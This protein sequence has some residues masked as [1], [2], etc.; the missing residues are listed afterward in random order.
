MTM[1]EQ[2][3]LRLLGRARHGCARRPRTSSADI[4]PW[5]REQRMTQHGHASCTITSVRVLPEGSLIAPPP[6]SVFGRDHADAGDPIAGTPA[7]AHDLVAGGDA[8][9]V[10]AAGAGLLAGAI[11]TEHR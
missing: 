1:C 7:E 5:R 11:G 4:G 9:V 10:G 6:A 8:V 2:V 3:P